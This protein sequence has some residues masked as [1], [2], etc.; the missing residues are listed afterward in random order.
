VSDD[1]V[2]AAFAERA[3]FERSR[4]E[5]KEQT[6]PAAGFHAEATAIVRATTKRLR[7]TLRPTDVVKLARGRLRDVRRELKATRKNLAALE[8]EETQLSRLLDA[9]DG[10]NNRSASVRELRRPA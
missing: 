3:A 6:D 2:N 8:R 7:S 10:K 5:P 1:S 4:G 9:A